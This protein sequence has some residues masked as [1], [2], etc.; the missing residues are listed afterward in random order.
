MLTSMFYITNPSVQQIR[1]T[2]GAC[3]PVCALL[4]SRGEVMPK[5]WGNIRN[6]RSQRERTNLEIVHDKKHIHTKC[7]KKLDCLIFRFVIRAFVFQNLANVTHVCVS[8][9]WIDIVIETCFPPNPPFLFLPL[10]LPVSVFFP[11]LSASIPLSLP[12][13]V[14]NHVSSGC[15]SRAN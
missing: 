3:L 2:K 7:S 13:L 14:P 8:P 6:T 11:S 15:T 1:K 9:G 5:Q 10:F 4:G 12:R